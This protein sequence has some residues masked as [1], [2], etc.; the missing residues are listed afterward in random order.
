[1]ALSIEA[2]LRAKLA[3]GLAAAAKKLA[4]EYSE[5]VDVPVEF[6][7]PLH[8]VRSV[9]G[10]Y[11]RK[12]TGTGQANI[13][14]AVDGTKLRAA[15]GV[16]QQ[17]EHLAELREAPYHRKYADDTLFENLEEIRQAFIDGTRG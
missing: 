6:I 7:T 9:P 14:W 4:D 16:K 12:E 2:L 5:D 15:V 8:V 10:E 1:M 17:G 3:R 13:G 11:P